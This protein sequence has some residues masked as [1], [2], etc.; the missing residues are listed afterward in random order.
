MQAIPGEIKALVTLISN[1]MPNE[2][3]DQ[4][5]TQPPCRLTTCFFFFFFLFKDVEKKNG[6]KEPETPHP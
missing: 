6:A 2:S 5:T 3:A 4:N 1:E